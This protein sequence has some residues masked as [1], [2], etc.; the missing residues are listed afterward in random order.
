MKK[1]LIHIGTEKTGTTSIQ[2]FLHINRQA[3]IQ[4]GVAYL[5]SP[6]LT[7]HRKLPIFCMRDD[8]VDDYVI[9]LG[10]VN[11]EARMRWKRE[12]KKELHDE[13]DCLS[14]K[15]SS[16]IISSEHFHS[17]LCYESE[18]RALKEMLQKHFSE[19]RIIVYLRRQDKLAVSSYSTYCKC[20][21]DL[22]VGSICRPAWYGNL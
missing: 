3:L 12:F 2:D 10:I 4:H 19:I 14:S 15:I 8:R 5:K 9:E 6:G 20:G 21:G 1:A 22:G 16:V 7:N 13:L 18:V 11:K 17:R